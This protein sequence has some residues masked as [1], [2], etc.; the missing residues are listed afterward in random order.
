MSTRSD[1]AQPRY[2]AQ[3]ACGS[4]GPIHRVSARVRCLLLCCAEQFTRR[5]NRVVHGCQRPGIETER[6]ILA[7]DAEAELEH[8]VLSECEPSGDADIQPDVLFVRETD[9]IK[10]IK[11]NNTAS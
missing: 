3:A 11:R 1:Q 4:P 8:M 10:C 9:G 2:S 7:T 5:F 6:C